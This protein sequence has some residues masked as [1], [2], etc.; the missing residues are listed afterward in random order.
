L[1]AAVPVGSVPLELDHETPSFQGRPSWF[2]TDGRGDRTRERAVKYLQHTRVEAAKIL[3]VTTAKTFD[4]IADT[5]GYENVS[6]LRRVFTRTTGMTPV[7][8]RRKFG[9]FA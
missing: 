9:D 2:S 5:V 4:D 3:L 7:E 8:F 1:P 6:F